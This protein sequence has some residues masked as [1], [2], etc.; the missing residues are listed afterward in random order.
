MR[1]VH[2][3][4]GYY[5]T[6]SACPICSM[7]RNDADAP[8][9]NESRHKGSWAAACQL[10]QRG[11]RVGG[12]DDPPGLIFEDPRVDKTIAHLV[13]IRLRYDCLALSD[14]RH[15]VEF[16]FHVV[17]VFARDAARF[18]FGGRKLRWPRRDRVLPKI[19]N[20]KRPVTSSETSG[21]SASIFEIRGDKIKEHRARNARR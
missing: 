21:V 15:A 17:D 6:G 10:L 2:F 19:E 12:R 9:V 8:N 11:I 3:A 14:R 4:G 20:T 5:T 1:I 16:N 13:A 7:A 18:V